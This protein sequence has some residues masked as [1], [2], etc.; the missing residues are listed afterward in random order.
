[1]GR[2]FCTVITRSHLA[3]ALALLDSLRQ[4]DAQLPFA[5]LV[6]DDDGTVRGKAGALEGVE[7]LG[8]ADLAY[9]PLGRGIAERYAHQS[10]ELRWSMK[11][12][13]MEY[14]L[15]RYEKVIY[16]DCDLHFFS[17]PAWLWK[18]LDTS[19]ILL[20][21][22]WRSSRAEVD[23]GNFDLLFVEGLYN[24]GFVAASRNGIPA[25]H[26]WASNC[27]SVCVKDGT[28]GHYVDQTHL[29]LLPVYFEGVHVLKHRGC[30]VANWNTVEC[31]RSYA[32]SGEVLI[33]GRWPVVFIHFTRSMIDGIISG[34]DGTLLPHVTT[35]RDRLLANGYGQDIIEASQVRI[36]ART[37]PSKATIRMRL[38]SLV[39]A[40]RGKN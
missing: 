4:Y 35:L 14:L 5:I 15:Q 31:A 36:A 39:R 33:D 11:G 16:G 2:I 1:M 37:A 40:V 30:N 22:H 29:N 6:T 17:D 10:D 24:G 21:P 20:S 34:E 7:V 26:R 23:R 3:W 9:A 12:V 27:L 18:E 25:L 28:R 38:G 13:L 8:L 32:P 19:G